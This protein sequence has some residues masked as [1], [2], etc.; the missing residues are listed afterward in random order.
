MARRWYFWLFYVLQNLYGFGLVIVL[1]LAGITV[2]I[3]NLSSAPPNF[4]K[5]GAGLLMGTVMVVW[6]LWIYGRNVRKAEE[7]LASINPV[8]LTLAAEGL[9]TVEKSGV[10]NF[11]PWTRFDGY[12]EGET[13]FL[14]C[15]EGQASGLRTIPKEG[16]S[17]DQIAQLRSAI[18]AHLAELR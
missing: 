15:G 9:Q 2:A 7:A 3:R 16:L 11:D 10:K 13:I 12:R 18:R 14:L 1:F 5:A 17:S 6:W 4:P 8:R